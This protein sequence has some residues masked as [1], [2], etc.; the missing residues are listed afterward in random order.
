MTN[1]GITGMPRALTTLILHNSGMT[2]GTTVEFLGQQASL[3]GTIQT[4]STFS[5]TGT[6]NA[7]FSFYGIAPSATVLVTLANASAGTTLG[8]S[9]DL[10]FTLSTYV[11][12]AS[13]DILTSVYLTFAGFNVPVYSGSGLVTGTV[14]GFAI[15]TAAMIQNN[16]LVFTIPLH[17][18]VSI[19]LPF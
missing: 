12:T 15:S 9:F 5:L 4:D 11:G 8:G 19:N 3:A 2:A 7:G 16:A 1:F 18:T 6:V 14:G 17:G 13:L 10:N